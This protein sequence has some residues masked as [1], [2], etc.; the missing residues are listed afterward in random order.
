MVKI[1]KEI[2]INVEFLGSHFKRVRTCSWEECHQP[3]NPSLL[4]FLVLPRKLTKSCFKGRQIVCP[5]LPRQADCFRPTQIIRSLLWTSSLDVFAASAV[6][7]VPVQIK[8]LL[9]FHRV[10]CL[11]NHHKGNHKLPCL[12]LSVTR[13]AKLCGLFFSDKTSVPVLLYTERNSSLHR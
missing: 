1:A 8:L 6:W 5:W 10:C 4:L 2:N 3:P 11:C 7:F 9:T 13:C 12:Q